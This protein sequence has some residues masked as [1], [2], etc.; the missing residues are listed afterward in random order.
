MPLAPLLLGQCR[1]HQ[2]SFNSPQLTSK[3]ANSIGSAVDNKG[4]DSHIPVPVGNAHPA[5]DN[6]SVCAKNAVHFR[7][8]GPV[9]NHYADDANTSN[10]FLSPFK[11][12]SLSSTPQRHRQANTH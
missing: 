8:T 1:F 10:H 12:K 7:D 3:G 9:L 2:D 11:V 6:I 4:Y 5:N